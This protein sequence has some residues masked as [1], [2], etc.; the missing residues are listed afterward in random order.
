[1]GQLLVGPPNHIFWWPMAH[2]VHPTAP[3]Y[4]CSLVLSSLCR[5][6]ADDFS[7]LRE[8][9]E[10]T[11]QPTYRPTSIAASADSLA[12]LTHRIER[13][14]S[15]SNSSNSEACSFQSAAEADRRHIGFACL[16]LLIT[17]PSTTVRDRAALRSCDTSHLQVLHASS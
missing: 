1:M 4:Y 15:S 3:S 2:R 11:Q 9:K 5:A 17:I 10:R 16:Y 7:E 14:C 8:A 13:G 12:E 6:C